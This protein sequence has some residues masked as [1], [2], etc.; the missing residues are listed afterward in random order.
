M[1]RGLG[2][3]S[4]GVWLQQQQGAVSF[5]LGPGSQ[6]FWLQR[7]TAETK[8]AH[9]HHVTSPSPEPTGTPSPSTWACWARAEGPRGGGCEAHRGQVGSRSVLTVASG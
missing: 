4:E 7:K 6:E 9:T 8:R 3:G 1:L 2:V 5:I